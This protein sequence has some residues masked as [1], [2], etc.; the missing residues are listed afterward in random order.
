[1]IAATSL[2]G[3]RAVIG[4]LTQR[5]LKLRYKRSILGW[6]WSLI[7]PAAVLF[8]YIVVF[9]IFLGLE[10]PV[11]G[12]GEL[13][14][15][16]IYL[17][18]GLMVWDFFSI[19]LTGS[20]GWLLASGSLLNKVYFPA[21]VPVLAGSLAVLVQTTTEAVILLVVLAVV[22]NISLTAL[23]LPLVMALLFLFSL[24][25]ALITS[26][27]NVYFRDVTH[28]V[29]IGTTVLFYATPIV[30][31]IDLV[32]DAI[33]G[34]FPIRDVI[35]FNPLTQFVS[36]TRDIVYG[37]HVPG[38][39]RLAFLTFVSV[40]TFGVGWTIFRRYATQLSEDL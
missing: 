26:L 40:V 13:R 9:G 15:F 3:Y 10:P 14:S 19:V 29:N 17:F 12:N 5:E 38:L 2:W 28:I 31:P 39:D 30:Y 27:A 6:L 11:A 7:N 22:D 8:V 36:A 35:L 21:E 33:W 32:P 1:M 18:A 20:M 4:H 24:G 37:L 16:P 34:D 23:L 25:L